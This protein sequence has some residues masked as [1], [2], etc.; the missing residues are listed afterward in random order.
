MHRGQWVLLEARVISK[1]RSSG[2]AKSGHTKR[3]GRGES[4]AK[5]GISNKAIQPYVLEMLW[6]LR[7]LL[8]VES[9]DEDEGYIELEVILKVGTGRNPNSSRDAGRS[10]KEYLAGKRP[11][12]FVMA[13]NAMRYIQDNFKSMPPAAQ[14][15]NKQITELQMNRFRMGLRGFERVVKRETDRLKAK[16]SLTP[17]PLYALGLIAR[18]LEENTPAITSDRLTPSDR[19]KSF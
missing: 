19:L 8:T 9:D 10:A 12:T 6:E 11:V 5:Y 15:L 3:R 18:I 1:M 7:A 4:W 13:K 14:R 16:A 2:P 17:D